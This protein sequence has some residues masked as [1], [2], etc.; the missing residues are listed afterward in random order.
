MALKLNF[1][2]FRVTGR[3]LTK[4]KSAY[5]EIKSQESDG[6]SDSKASFSPKCVVFPVISKCYRLFVYCELWLSNSLMLFIT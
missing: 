5:E 4:S 3:F 2:D 1:R 6:N